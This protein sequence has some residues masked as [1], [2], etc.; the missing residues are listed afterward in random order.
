[1][2]I[3]SEYFFGTKLSFDTVTDRLVHSPRVY[4]WHVT[5]A[6]LCVTGEKQLKDIRDSWIHETVWIKTAKNISGTWI[7]LKFVRE[8]RTISLPPLQSYFAAVFDFSSPR[9]EFKVNLRY[10]AKRG[11]DVLEITPF[12]A[13]S[14]SVFSSRLIFKQ[15]YLT[16]SVYSLIFNEMG[17]EKPRIRKPRNTLCEQLKIRRRRSTIPLSYIAFMWTMQQFSSA[18]S[19]TAALFFDTAT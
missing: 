10:S 17:T 18:L 1:M 9:F 15:S 12:L 7:L 5:K 4:A 8:T 2:E 16:W 19:R 6:K 14:D 3:K 13:A 11:T